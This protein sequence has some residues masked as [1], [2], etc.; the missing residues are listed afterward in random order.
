[1]PNEWLVES[2]KSNFTRE[3]SSAIHKRYKRCVGGHEDR[4][5]VRKGQRPYE[6]TGE[7]LPLFTRKSMREEILVHGLDHR[8]LSVTEGRETATRS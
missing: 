3:G 5:D 6:T 2:R 7:S 1:M 8:V 4:R